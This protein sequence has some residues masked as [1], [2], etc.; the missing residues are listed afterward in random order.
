MEAVKESELRIGNLVWDF[1]VIHPTEKYVTVQAIG[2]DYLIVKNKDGV[3]KVEIKFIKPIPLD[4]EWLL[5]FGFS[6]TLNKGFEDD[7]YEKKGIQI[8]LLK[9]LESDD[10]AFTSNDYRIDNNCRLWIE[11]VH[12]IQN[13]FQAL[14][15]E[16]LKFV[17]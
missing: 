2:E 1:N 3:Y 14:T 13:L 17:Y 5:K 6:Q 8:S 7:I 12:K 16:E 10:F 9:S 15:N 11:S 4:K